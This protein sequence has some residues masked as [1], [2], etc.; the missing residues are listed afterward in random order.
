MMSLEKMKQAEAVR[1]IQ[2]SLLQLYDKQIKYCEHQPE[3]PFTE[4][5][6]SLLANLYERL[7]SP[8]AAFKFWLKYLKVQQN[9]YGKDREQMITTYR[10]LAGFA[11]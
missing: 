6:I 3:H 2:L 10:K 1:K 11:I 5:V 8:A 9:V 4:E 7:S